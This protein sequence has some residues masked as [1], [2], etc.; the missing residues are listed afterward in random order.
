VGTDQSDVDV[1]GHGDEDE[2]DER[3]IRANPFPARSA[4]DFA[5]PDADL[6]I[7]TE[8]TFELA[9]TQRVTVVA[10]PLPTE[11]VP[12][13]SIR[14]GNAT[15]T[16]NN[17]GNATIDLSGADG[18]FDAVIRA[19]DTSDEEMGPDFPPDPSKKRVWRT[20]QGRVRIQS[21][22]IVSASPAAALVVSSG[23]LRAMLQPAW[24]KAPIANSRPGAVDMIVIHHT[25]GNLQG[26]LNEFL[27]GNRVSIHYLIAPNGDVYKLV[28]EDRVAAHAGNSHWQG[29][30]GMNGAS[31]GIEMTHISGDYPVAQV[32]ALVGLVEKLHHA[33]P[34]VP[35]GRVIGHSDIGIC[36][37][38]ATN[39][40]NPPAPKRLGRKSSD[41]GFTFPWERIERLGLS[42]QIAP[43][44]VAANMFGG[45]FQIRPNG[46]IRRGD[47]DAAHR[48]GGEV[49]NGVIGAVAELQRNLIKV[50][51]FCGD[52]DGD[53]GITTEMALK[54]FKQHMFSGSRQT[55]SGNVGSLDFATAEM[56]KRVRGEVTAVP[57]A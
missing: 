10:R 29:R 33:F 39:P 30:D 31:I 43:G 27:H 24:L 57:V 2:R 38:D 37:P 54:M 40:C 36:D 25:A 53:L 49:L 28:K 7:A 15:A 47:N 56:L 21:G 52:V 45:Y 14:I 8:S 12:N 17:S 6:A 5:A 9:S 55:S 35:P 16:T 46:A 42:L 19:P 4:P 18:E 26:D 50:G 48:F 13:C 34:G 32:D 11:G 20:L 22:A 3:D 51:Y 41:P 1:Q 44:T 23:T